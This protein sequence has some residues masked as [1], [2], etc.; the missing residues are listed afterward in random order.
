VTTDLPPRSGFDLRGLLDARAGE[1]MSLLAAHVNPQLAKVLR[2]IG[3]DRTYVRGAGPYLWDADGRRYLDFLSGYGMY[4][5]GRNHPAIRR[6]IRDYLDLD[7]PGKIQ[8]GPVLPAGLLAEALVDLAPDGL[9][10]VIFGNS[11]AEAVEA[12]VKLA[13]GATGRPG[14]VYFTN[15]FHGLTAGALSLNGCDSFRDGFV[16]FLPGAVPAPFGD[17]DAVSDLMRR[18]PPAAVIVEP[19]QGKGVHV[20]TPEFLLGL[21]AL[22]R[23]HRA[24]LI[25]DEIQTGLGR[26][27][28]MWAIDAVPG[29]EPDMLCCAKALSGGY[30]PIGATLIRRSTYRRVFSSM[31]RAVVHSSTFAGAGLAAACG[32]AT[33]DT[34]TRD[35]LIAAAR[36]L[37]NRLITGLRDLAPQYEM[38][39]EIRGEGLIIGMELVRPRSLRLRAGWSLLHGL[40]AGLFPQA[41]TIPLLDDHGI[42]TQV[43]GH[44]IDVIKLL[45][46]LVIT[47][48]D[49]EDFLAA[50]TQVMDAL[51]RFPGPL[52]DLARKFAR[53][54]G[55]TGR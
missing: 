29:L 38:L 26:T 36:D 47:D 42:L 55:T 6:A 48:A 9:D 11:G 5:L 35:G 1:Q 2:A 10:T 12:A 39:G 19:I 31:E 37:G 17:L 43:A 32:L 30:V 51:H 15:A 53:F 4:G 13:R 34:L 33:L 16:S 21:Q 14:V 50:F 8:L 22:C 24:L 40:N 7:D 23:R 28:R 44:N 54:A 49:V 52:W 20:A 41:V 46:P 25:V 18:E 27:G 3:F 45:P